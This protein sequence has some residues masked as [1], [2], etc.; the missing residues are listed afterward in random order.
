MRRLVAIP[1]KTS[2][3]ITTLMAGGMYLAADARQA[4]VKQRQLE[5]ASLE[6]WSPGANPA[7]PTPATIPNRAVLPVATDELAA[8][9]QAAALPATAPAAG[10][11]HIREIVISIADRQLA[12][13]QDGAL[14][15]IYPI[16]VGS[17]HTPSPD[18][19]F[20][21]INHAKDPVYRHSGKE[22]APG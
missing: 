16:A 1:I 10:D 11:G 5:L 8:E 21:I 2:I 6:K 7:T 4:V 15:K 18:G 3:L 12:L 20:E 17:S 13:F 19:E 22:I 9:K 14:V